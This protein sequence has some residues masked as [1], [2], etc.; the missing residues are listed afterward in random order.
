[1]A[2]VVITIEDVGAKSVSFITE[3]EGDETPDDA[4]SP[5]MAL[6]MASRALFETGLLA[7][8]AQVALAG[9]MNG[10]LPSEAIRNHYQ[11]KE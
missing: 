8:A 5:A 4:V 10:E 11:K 2:K 1:M 7:E 9:I 3:I 6:A